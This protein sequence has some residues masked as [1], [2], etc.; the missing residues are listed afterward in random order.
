MIFAAIVIIGGGLYYFL[1]QNSS[2]TNDIT[3]TAQFNTAVNTTYIDRNYDVPVSYPYS[4]PESEVELHGLNSELLAAQVPEE[5]S[6]IEESTTKVIT[7]KEINPPVR[8]E[9]VTPQPVVNETKTVPQ[10]VQTEIVPSKPREQV[11]QNVFKYNET[12][13]VQVAAFKTKIDAENG[14]AKYIKSGYSTFIEEAVVRG[15]KW[16][17]LRIGGFKTLGEAK[18]FQK[19]N[20]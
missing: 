5:Q 1:F 6:G 11:A 13:A 9:G 18:Q 10:N 2:E 16:Y 17:R 19:S 14:A 7:D 15:N 12:Y 8:N 4:A 3:A 20:K